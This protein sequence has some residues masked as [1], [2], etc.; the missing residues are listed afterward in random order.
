MA[1][2]DIDSGNVE[3]S[4]FFF[5]AVKNFELSELLT[6]NDDF[7]YTNGAA[8]RLYYSI[9]C[10]VKEMPEFKD[11]PSLKHS[12]DRKER[13][14]VLADI[15][16]NKTESDEFKKTAQEVY[17]MRVTADYERISVKQSYLQ[18]YVPKVADL[19]TKIYEDLQN[20]D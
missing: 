4:S 19:L 15:V 7:N 2:L 8:N 1:L 18:H 14:S 11:D 17:R 5:K 3:D 6:E 9:Y 20:G 13:H 16:Y 12:G 10:A